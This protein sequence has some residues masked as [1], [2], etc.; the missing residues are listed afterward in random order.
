MFYGRQ[1][2]LGDPTG[3]DDFMSETKD[4]F[5][6]LN[7]KIGQLRVVIE[8]M[9]DD[10]RFL[11]EELKLAWQEN[12]F[13]CVPSKCAS[14]DEHVLNKWHELKAKQSARN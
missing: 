2:Y 14:V 8:E 13:Y 4:V 12:H 10:A 5:N 3:D 1:F 9:A 11:E 6:S 7:Q